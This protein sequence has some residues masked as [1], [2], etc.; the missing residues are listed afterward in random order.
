VFLTHPVSRYTHATCRSD[1]LEGKVKTPDRNWQWKQEDNHILIFKCMT[2]VLDS[3]SAAHQMHRIA[4]L[5]LDDKS[6]IDWKSLND[7]TWD[8][9]S[10]RCL[11]KKW[12][13]LKVTCNAPDDTVSH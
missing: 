10:V 6:D 13:S 4:S 12:R 1:T 3:F 8:I 9:W 2:H 7:P 11:Q 5:D